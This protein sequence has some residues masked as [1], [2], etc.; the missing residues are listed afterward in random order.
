MTLCIFSNS[1]WPKKKPLQQPFN[2]SILC[3]TNQKLV[4]KIRH[5]TYGS[6][7]AVSV[8]LLRTTASSAICLPLS[9]VSVILPRLSP[10]TVPT[11][12]AI[13]KQKQHIIVFYWEQ[14]E[15]KSHTPIRYFSPC[16]HRLVNVQN[17]GVMSFISMS[18]QLAV[19]N[20]DTSL[21]LSSFTTNYC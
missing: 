8:F 7:V 21:F 17:Y 6:D 12:T 5:K 16:T 2:Q 19:M 14:N 11:R 10:I 9:A 15:S 20:I 13:Y 18:R 3:A 4:K 1:L